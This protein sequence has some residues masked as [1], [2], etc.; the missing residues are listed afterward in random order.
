MKKKNWHLKIETLCSQKVYRRQNLTIFF[1]SSEQVSGCPEPQ[2][3]ISYSF[4]ICVHVVKIVNGTS[5]KYH[6]ANIFYILVH[7]EVFQ[8]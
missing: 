4:V 7:K 8:F 3:I 1:Y 6:A 2:N 5:H